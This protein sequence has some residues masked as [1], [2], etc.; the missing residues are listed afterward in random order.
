MAAR[1]CESLPVPASKRTRFEALLCAGVCASVTFTLVA[2]DGTSATSA[3]GATQH[4]GLV[5]ALWTGAHAAPGK[6]GADPL[7]ATRAACNA[8][9]RRSAL[10]A[11]LAREAAELAAAEAALAARK[12]AFAAKTAPP[13]P[14][15]ETLAH[16]TPSPGGS[17]GAHRD[18]RPGEPCP[19]PRSSSLS[20]PG[21]VAEE[22]QPAEKPQESGR[23]ARGAEGPPPGPSPARTELF[24][25]IPR[26]CAGALIGVNGS[27]V[28]AMAAAA[29]V[30]SITVLSE[31]CAR[32]ARPPIVPVRILAPT[33]DAAHAARNAVAALVQRCR[34]REA[35]P[36]PQQWFAFDD[37]LPR[38]WTQSPMFVPLPPAWVTD[39]RC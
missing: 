22:Q 32:G 10:E 27:N 19:L 24:V 14:P 33:L 6:T 26:A 15:S 30:V 4:A 38:P 31:R 18:A 13:Q 3:L 16:A 17:F 11:E 35:V 39:E 2:P 36:A 25:D 7:A 12:R 20:D 29:G 28:R 5:A 9:A 23:S 34:P 1:G 37:G 21:G 8:L